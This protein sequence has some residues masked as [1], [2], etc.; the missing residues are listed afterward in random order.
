MTFRYAL[1]QLLS[2]PHKGR[3]FHLPDKIIGHKDS[4]YDRYDLFPAGFGSLKNKRAKRFLAKQARPDCRKQPNRRAVTG[5]KNGV[6]LDE[7]HAAGN[8][9][10]SHWA[11]AQIHETLHLP[12]EYLLDVF[13]YNSL[14]AAKVS[15]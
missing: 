12:P 13:S 8:I 14:L 11:I 2:D 7:V 15:F 10:G 1:S 4:N 5:T 6:T 9:A 3:R